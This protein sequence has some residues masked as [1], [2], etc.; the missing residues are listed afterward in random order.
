MECPYCKNELE[1]PA[2]AELNCEAYGG[3]PK[4]VTKC[5]GNIV[6][7]HRIVVIKASIPYN[8]KE[9]LTDDWGNDV[10]QHTK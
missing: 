6:G 9:I 1:I 8:H 7:L 10:A 4:V 3:N 2:Y 5:C